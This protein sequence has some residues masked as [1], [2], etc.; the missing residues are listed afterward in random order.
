MEGKSITKVPGGKLLKIFL[1]YNGKINKIKIT[2]DFFLHPEES[3]EQLEKELIGLKLDKDLLLD[4]I[5]I[6]FKD[7]DVKLFGVESSDIVSCI[8]N[9]SG[10]D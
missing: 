10:H 9:C 8:M 6:F 5:N 4:K 7:N 2:G 1:E 3:L